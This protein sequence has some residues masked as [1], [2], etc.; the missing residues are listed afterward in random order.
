MADVTPAELRIVEEAWAS[1]VPSPA[2]D[3]LSPKERRQF[4]SANP[5]S[6]LGVTRGPEDLPPGQ[7]MSNEDLLLDGRRSFDALLDQGAFTPIQAKRFFLYQLETDDHIQTAIVGNVATNNFADGNVRLHELVQLDR[8]TH[9]SRH[10]S[11]VGAQSSPIALAHRG[12][13]ELDNIVQRA[14]TQTNP[15]LSFA[16]SGGVTQRIW[17]IANEQINHRIQE[18]L[19]KEN[20]YLIDGHHRAAA[21]RAHQQAVADEASD[22]ILS[23]IFTASEL[24]NRA[25]H[26][27]LSLGDRTEDFLH[28]LQEQLPVRVVMSQADSEARNP[29]E[30][31]IWADDQCFLVTVPFTFTPAAIDDSSEIVATEQ[32][33]VDYATISPAERLDNLD[34]VRLQRGIIGPLL[35]VDGSWSGE[36]LT[37][38]PGVKPVED[39]RADARDKNEILCVMRPVLIQDLLDASDEGLVMPPKSTYFEPKARSGIFVRHL[40]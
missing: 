37:Y 38:R 11:V 34:P 4:L 5:S 20:L 21:A 35:G 36:Q 26:R 25:H 8:A 14:V 23:A 33:E 24:R 10:L 30:I 2:H 18:L 39:L 12:S 15:M 29:D 13:Q 22:Y 3:S 32:G 31:A 6:Y 17:E 40:N 16:V 19:A 1:L 28:Q 7:D 27:V 9:L